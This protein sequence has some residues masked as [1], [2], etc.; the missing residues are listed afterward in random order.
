MKFLNYR[1]YLIQLS[2]RDS[3][4]AT[5]TYVVVLRLFRGCLV[6]LEQLVDYAHYLHVPQS[7]RA[8]SSVY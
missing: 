7:S 8:W 4:Q 2:N 3:N 1:W 5:A 6:V